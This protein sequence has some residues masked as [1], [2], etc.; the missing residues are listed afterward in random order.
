MMRILLVLMMRW[1]FSLVLLRTHTLGDCCWW[2]AAVQSVTAKER[3]R[4]GAPDVLLL[5]RTH[6]LVSWK[7]KLV[8]SDGGSEHPFLVRQAGAS[9]FRV[10]N[11]KGDRNPREKRE[12]A[13]ELAS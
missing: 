8:T 4:E 12:K 9:L 5:Y 13:E 3:E 1:R 6:F 2:L 7:K 11:E 10:E